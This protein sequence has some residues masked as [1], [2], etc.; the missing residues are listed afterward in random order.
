MAAAGSFPFLLRDEDWVTVGAGTEGVEVEAAEASGSVTRCLL[1]RRGGGAASVDSAAGLASRAGALRFR[2][3]A[4]RRAGEAAA[5][6]AE[7]AARAEARVILGDMSTNFL[8][9]G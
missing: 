6:S 4:G 1:V 9:E 5:P 2:A 8:R 3:G 7:A